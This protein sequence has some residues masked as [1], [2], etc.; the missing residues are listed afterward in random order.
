MLLFME[1][2]FVTAQN[3]KQSDALQW[4]NDQKVLVYPY[5]R[6]DQPTNAQNNPGELI[7]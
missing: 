4:V 7:Q 6:A 3:W 5:H 1:V 2:L